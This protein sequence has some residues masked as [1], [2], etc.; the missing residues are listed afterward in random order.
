MES[1]GKGKPIDV[2]E[3]MNSINVSVPERQYGSRTWTL[4]LVDSSFNVDYIEKTMKEPFDPN[5]E[6]QWITTEKKFTID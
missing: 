5:E 6:I 1:Q 4:I 3:R 2:L